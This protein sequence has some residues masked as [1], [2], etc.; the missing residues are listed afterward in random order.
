MSGPMSVVA[1]ESVVRAR[2]PVTYDELVDRWRRIDDLQRSRYSEPAVLA[3]PARGV[4]VPLR[5]SVMGVG[6]AGLGRPRERTLADGQR[7]VE[8]PKSFADRGDR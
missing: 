2:I 4:E 7:V 6:D 8:R 1:D 3:M 5:R